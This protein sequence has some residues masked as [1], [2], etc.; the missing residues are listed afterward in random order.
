MVTPPI[1]TVP[2]VIRSIPARQRSS[3]VLPE[4][5]GPSRTR[6]VPAAT[7]SETSLSARAPAG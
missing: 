3:V 4:P 1:V 7:S 6:K 5:E 2:E